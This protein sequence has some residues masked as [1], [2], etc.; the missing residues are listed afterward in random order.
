M[1]NEA[2]ILDIRS[3]DGQAAVIGGS[4]PLQVNKRTGRVQIATQRGIVVNSM[5]MRDEWA[6]IDRTVIEAARYPLKAVNDLRTRGLVHPLGGLGSTISRWYM[7]SEVTGANVNMSGRGGANRDLP[8]MIETA[9]PVPVIFKDFEIDQRALLASRRLFDGIDMTSLR[10]ATRVVAEGGENLLVNGSSTK[11]NGVALYGY[12]THPNRITSTATALGGGA[13]STIANIVPTI[14]GAITAANN[15]NHYGPFVIYASTAQ[16]N[17]AAL[18]YYGDA[19]GQTP[20]QRILLMPQVAAFTLL[21]TSVLPAGELLMIQMDSNVADW[22]EPIDLV[23]VQV[24]E[25]ASDDGLAGMFK[26]MMVG[27]PRVKA[28]YDGKSGVVHITGA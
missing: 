8:E 26:V 9:S 14:N 20:M 24:R 12:R 1:G 28:R 25:W 23:G 19:S 7:S 17:Y 16:Y 15:Q 27:T 13:W 22:A 10:E 6:E 11:L 3:E 4:R 21:P 5:L 18:S 2:K